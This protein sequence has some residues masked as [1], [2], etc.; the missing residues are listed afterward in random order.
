[1]LAGAVGL[2]L[3]ALWVPQR[4]D[5]IVL[6][7]QSRQAVASTL[8]A[9]P[10]SQTAVLPQ[11][12]PA[13]RLKAAQRDPFASIHAVAPVIGGA[14]P[15]QAAALPTP[16]HAP[17]SQPAVPPPPLD[18]RWFGSITTPDGQ[19]IVL[20]AHAVEQQRTLPVVPGQQ[21][22]D[23]YIVVAV[24]PSAVR[25]QHP[26]RQEDVVIPIPSQPEPGR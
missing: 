11:T 12:L 13:I 8:P 7:V 18:W 17:P 15:P 2:S 1:M 10:A 24:E 22:D 19:R 16:A 4:A 5:R 3:L 21:L 20:L 25:L 23:G 9:A 6:A 26:L 14:R